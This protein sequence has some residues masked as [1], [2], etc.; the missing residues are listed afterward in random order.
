[1]LTRIIIGTV[2]IAATVGMFVVDQSYSFH[3]WYAAPCLLALS[4][5]L[6]CVGSLEL[7]RMIPVTRKPFAFL[8]VIGSMTIIA[9]HWLLNYREAVMYAFTFFSLGAFVVGLA[10]FRTPGETVHQ[11][12]FT[13][14]ALVYLGL[15]PGYFVDLRLTERNPTLGTAYLALAVFVP[16]GCDIG[17]YFTGKAIGRTPFAPVLSPKKTWEGIIGGLITAAIIAVCIHAY[18]TPVFPR[19]LH[20]AIAF[21][22]VIGFLGILG[23]L[24]E[25]M[26][27]REAGAKDAGKVLPEFGGVLDIVDSILFAAPVVYWW[28]RASP[29]A[30][31]PE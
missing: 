26:I 19:G 22:L 14:L 9:S 16:K 31:R 6:A 3:G 18:L 7:I 4:M 10:S 27:K 15:L 5:I 24:V 29:W 20:Q 23:D 11:I 28:L 30:L 13:I 2:L 17:A 8:T 21:G 25:S 1:M 12:A